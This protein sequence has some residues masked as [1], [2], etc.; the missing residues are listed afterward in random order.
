MN[1]SVTGRCLCGNIK[2]IYTGIIDHSSYC[3]CPDCKKETGSAFSVV[4]RFEK[5]Y[6]KLTSVH[7]VQEFTKKADD[8]DH[9]SRFF[10]PEC[11]ST[12]YAKPHSQTDYIWI[13]AGLLDD[14][15]IIKPSHQSWICSKV[16]WSE[17]P[18]GI[19][20]FSKSSQ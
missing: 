12:I 18:K 13:R 14:P 5:K 19:K 3:H 10:C 17:I 9:I 1:D 15:S 7:S 2:Y 6:F 11:G 4:V 16:K 20:S 8:G